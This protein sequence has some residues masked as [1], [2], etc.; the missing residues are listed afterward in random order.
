[1]PRRDKPLVI[2][3]EYEPDMDACVEALYRLLTRPMR[4]EE[5][6]RKEEKAS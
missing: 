5:Q 1:M 2:H 4:T 3:I 6:E